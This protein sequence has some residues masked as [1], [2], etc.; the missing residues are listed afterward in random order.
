M[1]NFHINIFNFHTIHSV[2]VNFFVLRVLIANAIAKINTFYM[3]Q[4]ISCITACVCMHLTFLSLYFPLRNPLKVVCRLN[5]NCWSSDLGRQ[6]LTDFELHC[7]VNSLLTFENIN[8]LHT[9]NRTRYI[10]VCA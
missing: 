9:N 5:S 6:T 7:H 10:G 2:I 4:K 8:G 1:P 3:Q